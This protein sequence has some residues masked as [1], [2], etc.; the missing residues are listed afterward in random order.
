[1]QPA[2]SISDAPTSAGDLW[3]HYPK[4]VAVVEMP[5][6]TSRLI[7]DATVKVR[8]D[9]GIPSLPKW[10]SMRRTRANLKARKQLIQNQLFDENVRGNTQIIQPKGTV[11]HSC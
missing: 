6:V 10:A 2:S 9:S 8:S 1:M 11:R 4:K 7:L 3:V 5:M